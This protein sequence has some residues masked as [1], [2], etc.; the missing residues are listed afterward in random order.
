MER[1]II[2]T[3]G[4]EFGSGG[5]YIAENVAKK[6]GIKLYDKA[7]LEHIAMKVGYSQ[8]D[9]E[10]YDEKPRN[11]FLSRRV[12]DYS[13]SIEEIMANNVFDFIRSKAAEGESFV[14]VGRCAEYVL[15]DNENT[16]KVFVRSSEEE[17]VRRVSE[18]YEVD[19]ARALEM[20]KKNDKQRKLYH[21]YYSDV[22]WG[23]CRG[24][25]ICLNSGMLGVDKS[26]DVVLDIAAMMK[27]KEEL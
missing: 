23:D 25:D 27:Y 15:R 11:P 2:I 1:Q 7:L 18:I 12:R 22:K 13:N 21:N 3:V 20:M 24:Y 6:L 5:H 4:R 19:R 8:D 26:V 14:V 9:M 10:K 16:L 17:K